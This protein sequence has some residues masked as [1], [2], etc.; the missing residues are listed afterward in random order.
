MSGYHVRLQQYRL[1]DLKVGH[2]IE[3]V[4]PLQHWGAQGRGGRLVFYFNRELGR[5]IL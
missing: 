2:C 4:E 3:D 5:F 1:A